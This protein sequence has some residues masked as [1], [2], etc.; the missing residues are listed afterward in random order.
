MIHTAVPDPAAFTVRNDSPA[1]GTVVL[2][3]AGY[4]GT[5]QGAPGPSPPCSV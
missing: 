3:P 2:L 4:P 1:E 5:V